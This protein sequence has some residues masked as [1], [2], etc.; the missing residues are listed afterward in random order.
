MAFPWIDTK[1]SPKPLQ[2]NHQPSAYSNISSKMCI[3]IR[4]IG[5]KSIFK[6]EIIVLLFTC[7]W[8]NYKWNFNFISSKD[9]KRP[10]TKTS[11]LGVIWWSKTKTKILV[12]NNVN[13]SWHSAAMFAVNTGVVALLSSPV[14]IF[15]IWNS[16][17]LC[18]IETIFEM[19]RPNALV[20]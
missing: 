6:F 14:E 20:M 5:V 18:I 1:H 13:R 11:S 3:F 2:A 10:C 9:H 16:S 8:M 19:F 17:V 15:E 12:A 7:F 4:K